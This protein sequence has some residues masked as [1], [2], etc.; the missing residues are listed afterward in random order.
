MLKFSLSFVFLSI[1]CAFNAI[2]EQI[3][4]SSD[5]DIRIKFV[6]YDPFNV[7]KFYTARSN[8]TEIVFGEG[9]FII[10]LMY[11]SSGNWEDSTIKNRLYIKPKLKTIDASNINILTN[12]RRYLLQANVCSNDCK[13]NV[14]SLIY[15]YG[16]DNKTKEELKIEE[17]NLASKILK[18]APKIEQRNYQYTAQGN[19]E[20][21]P[22]NAWDNGRFT[23]LQLA[24]Y[25]NIPAV[26]SVQEDGTESLTNSHIENKNTIVI[27][28]L[29]K[30]F[31]L[32]AGKKVLAIHNEN[33]G[34]QIIDNETN[35]SS[36]FVERVNND[37]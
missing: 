21:R 9:E 13:N 10:N 25:K 7:V 11:G 32:R 3:P 34:K 6:E 4:K 30:L 35:T 14:Y 8:S 16:K 2:A 31:I 36:V 1:S 12:K 18:N 15:T 27:H 5:K 22:V 26:Y 33:Y 19:Q 37:R 28:Q 24:N 20:L 17:H 29:S 23:Y